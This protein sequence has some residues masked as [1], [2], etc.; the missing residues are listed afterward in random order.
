VPHTCHEARIAAAF[1]ETQPDHL[2]LSPHD[3]RI[4]IMITRGVVFSTVTCSGS[5]VSC[6][7]TSNPQ[8]HKTGRA[9]TS[10]GCKEEAIWSACHVSVDASSQPLIDIDSKFYFDTA[11]ARPRFLPFGGF[12]DLGS[13][14]SRRRNAR[15]ATLPHHAR[16]IENDSEITRG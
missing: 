2:N 9:R 6:A 5:T 7:E 10:H 3:H 11:C 13:A 1:T 4:V 16:P 15:H 14:R 8:F 12:A